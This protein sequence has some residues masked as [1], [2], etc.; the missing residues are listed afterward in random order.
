MER[1]FTLNKAS[2][3][4]AE[5]LVTENLARFESA[6]ERLTER[7]EDSGKKIQHLAELATRQKDEFLVMRDRLKGVVD[8]IL[9]YFKST[10]TRVQGNPKPVM[11]AAVCLLGGYFVLNYFGRKSLSVSNIV[12]ATKDSPIKSDATSSVQGLTH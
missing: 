6:M 4:K 8:P 5:T 1:D 10:A 9:P 11:W 12:D 7:V 2:L 3:D